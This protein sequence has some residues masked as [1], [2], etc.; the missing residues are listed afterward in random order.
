VPTTKHK[1]SGLVEIAPNRHEIP[2]PTATTPVNA[3]AQRSTVTLKPFHVFRSY[4]DS[5]Y[6]A[7]SEKYLSW[8]L[9]A[10]SVPAVARV[11]DTR[12]EPCA[13]EVS[14]R[15]AHTDGSIAPMRGETVKD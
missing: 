9:G 3:I 15:H 7:P 10:P 8:K 2:K 5:I 11:E 6:L 14:R 4:T 13:M 1:P 12:F